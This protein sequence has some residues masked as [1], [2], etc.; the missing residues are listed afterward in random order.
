MDFHGEYEAKVF[1][2]APQNSPTT[3]MLCRIS[4]IVEFWDPRTSDS[5][6]I[7]S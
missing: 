6:L 1:I 5:S 3:S 7:K 4:S 2:S